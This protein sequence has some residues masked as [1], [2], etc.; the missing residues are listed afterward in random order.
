MIV[1]LDT[2]S[3][4]TLTVRISSYAC[5]SVH[6]AL[7]PSIASPRKPPEIAVARF[8]INLLFTKNDW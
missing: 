2:L 5:S 8:L 1:L 3:E 6:T 7:A 4:A